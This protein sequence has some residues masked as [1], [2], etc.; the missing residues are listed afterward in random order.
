MYSHSLQGIVD[1]L[2]LFANTL[3]AVGRLLF[4]LCNARLLALFQTLRV[5]GRQLLLLL[6]LRRRQGCDLEVL[7]PRGRD[8]VVVAGVTS[9][10]GARV[11][12]ND[13]EDRA[14][15]EEGALERLRL[16]RG[17]GEL[18]AGEVFGSV[19]CH[20]SY[21]PDD[22]K[23]RQCK[24][25]K[26]IRQDENIPSSNC[27]A[28]SFHSVHGSRSVCLWRRDPGGLGGVGHGWR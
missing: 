27:F 13:V 14:G 2:G 9:S 5:D 15:G 16:G 6:L 12:G 21:V 1:R 25:A 18:D 24:L 22:S 3:P 19:S 11:D 20:V 23:A 7:D 17:G 8:D 4:Q 26:C 10:G 28:Q